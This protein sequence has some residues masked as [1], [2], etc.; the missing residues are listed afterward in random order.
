MEGER[1]GGITAPLTTVT[2]CDE[3]WL[4]EL[5]EGSTAPKIQVYRCDS[6]V[7]RSY[8]MNKKVNGKWNLEIR[9]KKMIT[10]GN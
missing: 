1:P 5:W 9:R 8:Y 7:D 10:R 3:L 2:H 6:Y 4:L